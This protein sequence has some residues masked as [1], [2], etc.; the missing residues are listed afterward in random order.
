MR[1]GEARKEYV[2]SQAVR[3]QTHFKSRKSL[4]RPRAITGLIFL[5]AMSAVSYWGV[6][7]WWAG[8]VYLSLSL[9]EFVLYGWDKWSAMHG[10]RRTPEKTLQLV[11]LLGGWPGALVAQDWLHHKSLKKPFQIVFW[12]TVMLNIAGLAL[13][14]QGSMFL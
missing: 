5:S 9:F 13:V 8:A 12:T 3:T 4:V 10:R 1:T 6:L 2:R 11:S 14:L 7:S